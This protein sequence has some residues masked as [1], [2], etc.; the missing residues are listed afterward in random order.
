MVS[1][2]VMN[3]GARLQAAAP[4]GGVLVGE[5]TH[6]ATDRVIDYRESEPIEAKGKAKPLPAWIAL[7]AR[8]SFGIDLT[9]TS[10][11]RLVGRDRELDLLA[12]ALERARETRDPQLV[13]LVGV[14]GIGK[15]RLVRE[16]FRIVDE[17]EEL[18]FWRQGRSLPYGE[19]VAYWAFGEMVKAQAG[20]LESDDAEAAAAKLD[21]AVQDLGLDDDQ[22]A[23]LRRHLR[24][25]VGLVS[26]EDATSER[27]EVFAAWRRLVE[28][29]AE[30]SPAVFVFEDLQWADDGMLDFVDELVDWITGVPLLVVAS[31]RP[32]LLE[33]RPGWG[34]GKRNALT[35]SLSPLS[36]DD[37]AHLLADLLDRVVLPA[38][39]QRSL[40][41]HAAGNPLFAEEYARMLSAGDGTTAGVPES[42]QALVAGRIDGLPVGEKTML[43]AGAVLGKVFWTDAVA[44]LVGESREQLVH[45]LRPLERKE[46]VRRERR[47]AVAGGDQYTFMHALVRDV[48]YG[49]MPRPERSRWHLL[50]AD[51]IESLPADRSEDRAEMLA[52][53]LVQALEYDRAVRGEAEPALVQR[54]GAA[55]H[56]AGDRAWALGAY[57][58]AARHYGAA[59]AAVGDDPRLLLAQ[60]RCLS[61]ADATGDVELVRSA[62][63][64]LA[65]GDRGGAAE[66][67]AELAMYYRRR[68][69]GY[70]ATTHLDRATELVEGIPDSRARAAVLVVVG[71]LLVLGGRPEEGLVAAEEASRIAA[72]LGIA[73]IRASALNGVALAKSALHHP[74]GISALEEALAFAL[75]VNPGEAARGYINLASTLVSDDADVRRGRDVHR[76]GLRF[77]E[78]FGLVWHV[79]WLKGELALDAY[80]LGDWQEA[81]ELAEQVMADAPR[82]PHYMDG[83]ALMV[84]AMIR[85]AR[86]ETATPLDDARRSLEM[87]RETKEPQSLEPTLAEAA[88]IEA[89]LGGV[90]EARSLITE[91]GE[92]L[93]E[94]EGPIHEPWYALEFALVVRA[95]AAD[96]SGFEVACR[97]SGNSA[98]LV[99]AAAYLDGEFDRSAELM[100]EIGVLVYAA[101]ARVAAAEAHL[102][103]GRR[104]QAAEQLARALDFYRS[105]GAAAFIAEAER[106]LPAAS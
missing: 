90:A 79:R 40:L 45:T 85:A 28:A 62:A 93:A 34:G 14:P 48:A 35:I 87:A 86:G 98:W 16:L 102:A 50:A 65:A 84:R 18:I 97:R 43:Q 52:H 89:R 51:W 103:A 36:N 1:G 54:V 13:T 81:L 3:T 5:A 101:A 29:L 70:S 10:G 37:T 69:D 53:H 46:F 33:R 71:R 25:L 4:V 31:A 32:E 66:A 6:R 83:A 42:L 44:A 59:L 73:E 8:S 55:A 21:R 2:D 88:Y 60:G 19:G 61:L 99:A 15:S 12:G 24:P 94:H 80:R 78:R 47:S 38:D 95:C 91:L 58:A 67:E 77:A 9:E 7:A 105:V 72:E 96:R 27:S 82:V 57:A 100:H 39:T 56:E 17:E 106:L 75:E 30:K 26:G 11:A 20:I 76:E 68:G 92:L 63:A 104:A 22:V 49:Q 64:F 74:D 41:A 23:W